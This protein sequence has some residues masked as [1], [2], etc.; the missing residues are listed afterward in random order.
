LQGLR[1]IH[2]RHNSGTRDRRF[3]RRRGLRRRR[4]RQHTTGFE[5]LGPQ[6]DG[7]TLT[8]NSQFVTPVG[9]VIKEN[10]RPMGLALNPDGEIAAALNTDG[11]TT[12]IVSIFDLVNNKVLQQTG[13]GMISDGGLLYSPDGKYF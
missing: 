13:S 1:E 7:S 6:A 2:N 4:I 3:G 5:N 12:S 10:G 9:D 8:T 11:G